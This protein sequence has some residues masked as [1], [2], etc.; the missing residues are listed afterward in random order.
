[1]PFVV[2]QPRMCPLH[3]GRQPAA[4]RERY[5]AVLGA[6]PD[7][8]GDADALGLESPRPGESQVVV[9]PAGDAVGY[10]AT[11]A[12]CQDVG[13]FLNEGSPVDVGDE[14]TKGVGNLRAGECA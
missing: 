2:E 5:P 7:G 6:G 13:E 11:K 8:D 3:V 10:R 4:M 12:P 9:A 14:T 1:M